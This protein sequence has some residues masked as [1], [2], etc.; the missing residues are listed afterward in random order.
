[1]SVLP[2]SI[3]LPAVS[4]HSESTRRRCRT[5]LNDISS[6]SLTRQQRLGVDAI[7]KFGVFRKQ[8]TYQCCLAMPVEEGPTSSS[9][10]D[11]LLY[12]RAYWVTKS[13]VAW[14][15]EAAD[16]SCY[17]YASKTAALY[18]ANNGIEDIVVDISMQTG[19]DLKIKL[20]EDSAGLPENVKE[21]FP[22]IRDYRA[23]KVPLALDVKSLLKCQLAVAIFSCKHFIYVFHSLSFEIRAFRSHEKVADRNCINATGMQLPGVVDELFSY[24]G[25]LGA[26]FSNGVV[27]LYLWAPTAQVVRAYI[28]R[29]PSGSDP[30]EILELEELNGVW[31]ANGP[32]NWEGCYYVYEV[33]VYHPSTLQIQKCVANDPYSRG[34]SAN[35]MRTLLVN[36]DSD[37]LKP[38]GWDNL[39]DEKPELFSFSDI[40][41]Y[42]LHIR[43][44][45]YRAISSC[46]FKIA[47]KILPTLE[48]SLFL[49]ASDSTVHPDFRGG[50]LAFTSQLP[51]CFSPTSLVESEGQWNGSSVPAH[52]SYCQC[53]G[54][55]SSNGKER[56]I[57]GK[58]V[59]A[60]RVSSCESSN[61]GTRPF[62]IGGMERRSTRKRKESG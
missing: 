42:E 55:P 12:S 31:N 28:Y 15:V 16:G 4:S 9:S 24:N 61:L 46:S 54:L 22:H 39:A 58:L 56:Q 6:C 20:E 3:W 1:M 23:Y 44:F 51:S 50:Y 60:F 59:F 11:S 41:I 8:T 62:A 26:V 30:L 7:V 35:G 43:D 38:E 37:A 49:L 18:V 29:D 47:R 52:S 10:Q 36:L 33:T 14:N 53:L 19:H 40:S 5:H 2:S 27:S 57:M 32:R 48:F 17:L 45:R 25:P 21:K 13:I 34:L